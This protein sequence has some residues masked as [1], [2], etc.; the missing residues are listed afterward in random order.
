MVHPEHVATADDTGTVMEIGGRYYILATGAAADETDRVLKQGETF[1]IF[2]RY[3][4][5]TP[6]GLGEEGIFH[7]G[8]HELTPYAHDSALASAI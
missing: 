7:L 6:T 1:A 4:D 3:G 2:D 5:V 8:T